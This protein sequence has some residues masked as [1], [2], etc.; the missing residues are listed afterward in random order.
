MP[1]P[2]SRISAEEPNAS[3]V[4][5]RRLEL[6]SQDYEV[7]NPSTSFAGKKALLLHFITDGVKTS[8]RPVNDD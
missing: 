6:L 2:L 5:R 1:R 3:L 4:L 7:T 8:W